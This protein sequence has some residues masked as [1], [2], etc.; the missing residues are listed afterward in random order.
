MKTGIFAFAAVVLV[1]CVCTT[2]AAPFSKLFA[3]IPLKFMVLSS[4]TA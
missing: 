3:T 2:Y 1:A 4:S